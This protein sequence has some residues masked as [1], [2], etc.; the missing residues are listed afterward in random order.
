M[1]S[2]P[3]TS[4]IPKLVH[5]TH[6]LSQPASQPASPSVR[7]P[8]R[9][10]LQPLFLRAGPKCDLPMRLLDSLVSLTGCVGFSTSV[11]SSQPNPA[12]LFL[13]LFF[14]CVT[15]VPLLLPSPQAENTE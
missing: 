6:P 10:K 9:S 7:L 8:L 14:C 5:L 11:S 13:C 2:N 12:F 3:I 15:M 1:Q 4:L